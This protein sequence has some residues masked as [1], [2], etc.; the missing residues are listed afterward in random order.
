MIF[1]DIFGTCL[2]G[3]GGDVEMFLDSF[4]EGFQRLKDQQETC[5]QLYTPIK[6]HYHAQFLFPVCVCVCQPEK[7][8]KHKLS[9][10]PAVGSGPELV[11]MKL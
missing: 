9:R 1:G 2:R 3:F 6:P 7:T 8:Y 5:K 11:R 4:R 10:L